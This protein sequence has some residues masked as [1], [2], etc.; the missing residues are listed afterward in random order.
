MLN[1]INSLDIRKFIIAEYGVDATHLFRDMDLLDGVISQYSKKRA[2]DIL[3]DIV[4]K[5]EAKISSQA[6]PADP[7]QGGINKESAIDKA[8]MEHIFNLASQ[9]SRGRRFAIILLL[10]AKAANLITNDSYRNAR[11]L[12]GFKKYSPE[13]EQALTAPQS[14]R[15]DFTQLF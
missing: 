5:T 4:S 7:Q 6:N 13:M 2:A 15:D 8:V 10:M 14:K 1:P 12:W 9:S 3:S 11:E